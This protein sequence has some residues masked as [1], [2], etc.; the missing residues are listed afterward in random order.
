MQDR[1]EKGYIMNRKF[2][3]QKHVRYRWFFTH[4]YLQ[5]LGTCAGTRLCGLIT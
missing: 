3:S 1:T 5:P 2:I 4:E